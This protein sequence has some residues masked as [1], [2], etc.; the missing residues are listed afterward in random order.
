MEK[1]KITKRQM[2]DNIK[3]LLAVAINDGKDHSAEIAF[4]ENEIALIDARNEREKARR[5]EKKA[6][7]DEFTNAVIEAINENPKTVDDLLADVVDRF[8]EATRSQVIYRANQA[9]KNGAAYKFKV[10]TEK[11][12]FVAYSTQEPVTEE[13]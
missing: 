1:T 13:E 12:R 4:L 8:P 6:E 5:A 10:K 9:V 7:G 2:F 11:G 3:V